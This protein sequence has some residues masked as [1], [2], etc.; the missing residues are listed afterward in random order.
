MNKLIPVIV[1]LSVLSSPAGAAFYTGNDLFQ[2]CSN[3]RATIWGFAAGV[4]DKSE[5]DELF[6]VAYMLDLTISSN[7][8]KTAEQT[9]RD[10]QAFAQYH[11][12]VKNYCEP[13]GI[14]LRQ[15]ADIFCQF[16]TERPAMRHMSAAYLFNEALTKSW[17]CPAAK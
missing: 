14:D 12:N 1:G 5:A 10:D 4:F 13:K 15:V 7:F 16:L 11:S 8:N 17:P 3:N 6:I 9:K 2:A